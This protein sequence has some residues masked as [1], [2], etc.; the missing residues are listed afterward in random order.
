MSGES[1]QTASF[2]SLADWLA[3]LETLSPREIDL[4]LD[5]ISA[6]LERMQPARPQLVIH[7]AGTNGKGSTVEMLRQFLM[8]AGRRV[9]AYTSPHLCRYNE[10]IRVDDR[11][12]TDAEILAAFEK[13][14]AS[15]QGVPLT[16]FEYGTLAAIAV[17]EACDVD[18]A[19]L[20]I[21]LGGRL[22]AVNAIE[23]DAGI[24]TNIS[25][26]HADWLGSDLEGIA[27]EK[28]GILRAGRPFVF[29]DR[30]PRKSIDEKA[31]ACG[32][33]L[34]R[35]GRDFDWGI[36]DDGTWHWSG[37][38]QRLDGLRRPA[39]AGPF[40]AQ[41]AAGVLTLLEALGLDAVLQPDIVNGV[42]SRLKVLGR[43]Q[44]IHRD[45]QW[46][47]DVAHNPGSAEA[48]AAAL[49]ENPA[50][51]STVC[52]IGILADKEPDGIIQPLLEHVDQWIAVTP[53]S[54]R[55]REAASLGNIIAALGNC[56]VRIAN[57]IEEGLQIAQAGAAADDRVLVCGSFYTVGPALDWLGIYSDEAL[58]T[59]GTD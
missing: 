19:V 15:R 17:F 20:E 3:W 37:G 30:Q 22:D 29:G 4:G 23:P 6:V 35:A 43:F 14:E 7:V 57:S 25:L 53:A 49:R 54:P 26:D 18:A 34:L 9:G 51:G 27:A 44:A 31:R 32:A 2:E 36:D 41:N 21:G 59:D 56:P 24:I 47:V 42:M 33:V 28:A 13:V 40:Q 16:Y 58:A 1:P 48:L 45:C 50:T 12:A 10:R 52:V 8:A 11:Y 38:R 39:L 46:I 55:A 5:R